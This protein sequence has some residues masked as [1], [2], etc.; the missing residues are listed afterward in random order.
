MITNRREWIM[1]IVVLDGYTLN[2]GDLSWQSLEKLGDLTI[3]ERTP[4]DLIEQRIAGADIVLTNKVP[5]TRQLIETAESLKYIGVLATGYNI[6]DVAAAAQ[7]GIPVC[8]VPAYSADAVAQFTFALLLDICHRVALHSDTV[9]TGEWQNCQDFCYWKSPLIE[10]VGKTMGLVGYGKIGKRVAELAQAFGMNVMVYHHRT[11]AGT[12]QGNIEFVSLDDLLAKADVISLHLPLFEAT[13]HLI[14]YESL[15]KVKPSAILINTSR[16]PL[17][18]EQAVADALNA[19][20]LAHLAVDVVSV[21]PIA[22]ENPLLSARNVTITPHI[23]WAPYEARQRLM[24]VTV[25]NI[26]Q[27]MAGTPVNQVNGK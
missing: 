14:G 24:A 5:L 25:D 6:V 13:K 18:D 8:N 26:E 7:R 9:K 19:G 22:P 1:K 11:A 20:K 15:K 16:G 23:A 4:A 27:F 21:E 17:I 10:L 3:Y 2:P 12:R